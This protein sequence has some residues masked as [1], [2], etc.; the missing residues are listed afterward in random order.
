MLGPNI[1]IGFTYRANW[2]NLSAHGGI[3]PIFYLNAHQKMGIIPLLEPNYADYSQSTW[4]S[5]Y[6][7]A[8]LSF[9]LFKYISLAF[10][11]DSSRLNYKVIDFDNSLNWYN[12]ERT[13]VSQS[14][15]LEAS[16]L[17][18]L[19]GSLYTQIGYGHTFDFIQL[20]SASP[21]QSSKQYLILSVK[22]IK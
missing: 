5:P 21:I 22:M 3:V 6:F 4:G 10:L 11:Y 17:I 18:P 7:Y 2:L 13:V 9:I 15:K 16:L 19:Q 1:E 14:L 20:D 8:D 12:P